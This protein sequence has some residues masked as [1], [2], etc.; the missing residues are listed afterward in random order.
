MIF[1]IICAILFMIFVFLLTAVGLYAIDCWEID[2]GI[3]AIGAAF[4][5]AVA[6]VYFWIQVA[7]KGEEIKNPETVIEE[8][9]NKM[10]TDKQSKWTAD[11]IDFVTRCVYFEVGTES[12]YCQMAVTSVILNQLNSGYWGDDIISIVTNINMYST[13]ERTLNDP[14]IPDERTR[15]NVMFVLENG[16]IIDERIR[17]FRTD[18]HFEWPSYEGAFNIENVYFGY[19]ADSRYH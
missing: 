7:D 18:H 15:R 12:D 19:F 2:V 17:Y 9:T 1:Y 14:L 13:A 8:T 16:S 11:E 3:I 4:L 6:S 5:C 10:E